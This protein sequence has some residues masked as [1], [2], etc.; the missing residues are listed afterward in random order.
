MTKSKYFEMMADDKRW[1]SMTEEGRQNEWAA[2]D[3]NSRGDYP[4]WV[5]VPCGKKYGRSVP[6]LATLHEG[7]CGVCGE[8]GPVTEPRDFGHLPSLPANAKEHLPRE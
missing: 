4:E 5:C 8:S 3:N 2:M 6:E 1:C 7:V